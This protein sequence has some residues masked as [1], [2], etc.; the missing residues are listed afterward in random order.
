M[1]IYDAD[2]LT[3]KRHYEA[4][5]TLRQI[6]RDLGLSRQRLALELRTRGVR[7]RGC[8]PSETEVDEMVR[9]YGEGESL[10]R[11]GSH[12]GFSAGTVRTWLISRG[13]QMRDSHGRE[14]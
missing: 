11:V 2:M 8:A 4:G 7:L 9:R 12:L 13:V 14:R 3:A 10:D 6:A 5:A 1:R